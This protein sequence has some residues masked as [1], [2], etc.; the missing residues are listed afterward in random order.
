MT[1][2]GAFKAYGIPILIGDFLI[3]S[4]GQR[5]GSRKKVERLRPNL[6]IGWTGHLLAAEHVLRGLR[7]DLKH[8][9]PSRQ[10]LEQHLTTYKTG[11]LLDLRLIGWIVDDDQDCFSWSSWWPQE[12]FYGAPSYDGSGQHFI[13]RMAGPGEMHDTS[14]PTIV[15]KD[16]AL[17]ASLSIAANLMSAEILAGPYFQSLGFGHAYEILYLDKG[18]FQYATS[19]LYL[20]LTY[21]LDERGKV[22][23]RNISGSLYKYHTFNEHSVIDIYDPEQHTHTI[24]IITAPGVQNT[25][26]TQQLINSFNDRSYHFPSASDYYCIFL[27]LRAPN[28]IGPLLSIV[29]QANSQPSPSWIEADNTGSLTFSIPNATI[30]WMYQAIR[31][32]Q[33]QSSKHE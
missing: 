20:V 13:E 7:D 10:W 14:D 28:Y 26:K 24:D 16:R 4:R 27:D 17:E 32:D 11:D 15:D 9:P 1:L 30:E 18:Q 31:D 21:E 33:A 6:V 8:S 22:L 25:S 19:I 3:S 23:N 2:I 5:A 29:I 12:V